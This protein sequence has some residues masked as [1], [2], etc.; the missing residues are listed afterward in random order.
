M[1]QHRSKTKSQVWVVENS[2]VRSR[3]DQLATEEP[4]EIRLT[5]PQKTV[6]VTMRTPGADFELAAGF[7]YSE[8]IVKH[9]DDIQR[10]SYCVDSNRDGEQHYNIVNVALRQELTPDLQPLERHFFTTSACGICGKASLEALRLRG[11]PVMS[12]AMEVS[13][14]VIYSLSEQL[15]SAQS[16]FSTTGGIHAAGLF[17]SQGELLSLQEDV[18]RHNAVDKLVGSAL[19]TNQL[20]LSDRIVMVSGRSSFEILQ[21]CLMAR[22]PI[23]CAVSAPSSLAVTLAREFGITLVGFLRGKRFNVYS[24][25][26]RICSLSDHG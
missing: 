19:L 21:K 7:L 20:P 11:C 17:N 14:E 8:G 18:G 25:K 1:N 3:L 26:E 16:V 9:R 13:T 5:S 2:Q 6:A 22:V 4:L 10:I 15:R 24:G 23:V 12:D